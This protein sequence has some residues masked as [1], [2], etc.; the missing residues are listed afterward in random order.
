M[1]IENKIAYVFP[2][3]GSQ[4]VGMGLEL[5]NQ[6]AVARKIYQQADEILNYPLSKLCFNGPDEVLKRT[7][8]AQPAIFVTSMAYLHS[9]DKEFAYRNPIATAGHSLGEYSALVLAGALRFEDALKLVRERGLLMAAAEKEGGGGMLAIIMLPESEIASICQKTD[10]QIANINCDGQIV[11][12]GEKNKLAIAK[13]LAVKQGAKRVIPL[14]VSG[15]FHSRFM[16]SAR[17]GLK[18]FISNIEISNPR[19]LVIGNTTAHPLD[20]AHS[21]EQELVN[22][23]RMCVKWQQSV[24]YMIGQGINTFVE[25][26]PGAVLTGL[27][28]RINKYCQTI[29]V[30][31]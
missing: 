3:Q 5:Y 12:S 15:A 14:E 28:K 23:V 1:D 20:N 11:I 17:A 13:E 30:G 8:N 16:E 21:V 29:N 24:E 6:S 7:E 26:G 9:L 19:I 18:K 31:G 10:T 2:G 27:I 4:K 22:Q 25:I